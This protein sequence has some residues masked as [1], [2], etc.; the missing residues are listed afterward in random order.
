MKNL[1]VALLQIDSGI[2]RNENQ[3]KGLEACRE[4]KAKGADIAVFPEM[5]ANGYC[6]EDLAR[7]AICVD[8]PFVEAF[9]ADAKELEMAIVITI[10]EKR[11][12]VP[13]YC[14]SAVLIDR[15]G[16]RKMV[17]SKVHTCDFDASERQLTPGDDFYVTDLDTAAGP[18]HVGMMICY[19]REQPESAR[20]LMLKGAEIVLV[21]NACPMEIYRLSQLRSRAFENMMSI[22]TVNYPQT[23]EDCNGHS[24]AFDAQVWKRGSA[25][26]DNK[27]LEADGSE[28]IFTVDFDLDE[29]RAYRRSE[30]M[31]NAYRHPSKYHLLV[32]ETVE[33]PFVRPDSRR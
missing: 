32:E 31:G 8:D 6:F 33:E 13:E 24:S 22:V 21:P 18:V 14:N 29:I 23:H 7:D 10:P 28:G 17:Y 15:H 11:G 27:L 4:A 26:I 12:A 20:I 30:V 1:R 2:D 3:R 16:E 25:A 19:D 9:R 5:W